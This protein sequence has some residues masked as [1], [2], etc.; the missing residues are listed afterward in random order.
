MRAMSDPIVTEA[1][2]SNW[3]GLATGAALALAVVS[4]LALLGVLAQGFSVEQDAGL[5]YK[6]GIA[7]L[8]NLDATPVG[9]M[10]LVVVALIA[11]P[12]A[13]GI[14]GDGRQNRQAAI[15]LTVV[16]CACLVVIFGT[17]LGVITRLH[18]DQGPGQAV[19]SATRRVL[20]TF[21]VRSMGP[22]L[23]AF[24]AAL[25]VLPIRFP[26]PATPAPYA[27]GGGADADDA[28]P[29]PGTGTP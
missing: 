17:V 24:G 8:R 18:F 26:R 27:D 22:A 10:A 1:P 12:A 29:G 6:M 3:T 25:A 28:E 2:P 15:A 23:V 4:A 11:A 14:A 16:L 20:A 19:T 7:F 21:V 5:A 9:L 13:A